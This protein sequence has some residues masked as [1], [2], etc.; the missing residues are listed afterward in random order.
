M[1]CNP[2][3]TIP[4]TITP[5]WLKN[6]PD[7]IFVFGDNCL[8]VGKKG[9]AICRGCSNAYGFITKKIPSSD[10]DSFY[11]PSQYEEIFKREIEKLKKKMQENK[12]KTFIIPK[13]GSGLANKYNIYDKVIKDRIKKELEEFNN[14]IVI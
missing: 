13:L 1:D 12:E 8:R 9:Q 4:D 2:R 10:K 11:K 7:Y 5:Q 14:V 3:N 6:N